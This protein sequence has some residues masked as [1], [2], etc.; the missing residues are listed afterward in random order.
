M[1]LPLFSEMTIPQKIN[2]HVFLMTPSRRKPDV[3]Q[4]STVSAQ[5]ACPAGSALCLDA[6][7]IEDDTQLEVVRL[8]VEENDQW[9][10]RS[11]QKVMAWHI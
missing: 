5:G 2:R 10:G 11:G 7:I 6:G 1:A 4:V 8:H 9:F 3:P